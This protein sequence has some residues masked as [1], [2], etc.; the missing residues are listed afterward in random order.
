MDTSDNIPQEPSL[1]ISHLTFNEVVNCNADYAAQH[2]QAYAEDIRLLKKDPKKLSRTQLLRWHPHILSYSEELKNSY[3]DFKV[4]RWEILK[5]E[6]DDIR[7]ET[8]DDT[9][10]VVKEYD[11]ISENWR[12]CF[13]K[14]D[15]RYYKVYGK[16]L[17]RKAVPY[18]KLPLIIEDFILPYFDK[19]PNNSAIP[20][21]YETTENFIITE[22]MSAKDGWRPCVE[23][24][25]GRLFPGT[26]KLVVES[27]V[28][29]FA[30]NFQEIYKDS[31]A[32][33]KTIIKQKHIDEYTAL[34]SQTKIS[35]FPGRSDTFDGADPFDK[36][37]ISNIE[38]HQFYLGIH[39]AWA[40]D[41]VCRINPKTKQKEIK[42]V[43]LE[44]FYFANATRGN[45]WYHMYKI[46]SSHEYMST[47]ME[48]NQLTEKFVQQTGQLED[49]QFLAHFLYKAKWYSFVLNEK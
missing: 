37:L 44:N 27:Y 36:E 41:F 12:L 29:E 23:E 26:D 18:N 9:M 11:D 45:Y 15:Q 49:G 38:N 6:I 1:D 7:E 46:I 34:M 32:F 31:A 16:K 5:I 24:D 39:N 47:Y 25:F 17:W 43:D 30:R 13:S 20:T 48:N 8:G 2:K 3:L 21:I 35:P 19:I 33:A 28:K 10:V 42:F 4:N 40:A 22:W 14:K